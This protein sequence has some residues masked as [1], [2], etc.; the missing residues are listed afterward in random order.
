M[1]ILITGAL[2]QDGQILSDMHLANGD[3]VAGVIRPGLGDSQKNGMS[4]FGINLGKKEVC[5]DFLEYFKPDVIYHLAAVH[6][7]STNMQSILSQNRTSLFEIQSDTTNNFIKY[8]ENHNETHLLVALSS[9]MY[10]SSN[11]IRAIS[12][13]SIV[14]PSDDYGIAKSYSLEVLKNAREKSDLRVSGLI[15]FNHTSRLSKKEFLFPQIAE[16]LRTNPIEQVISGLHNPKALIDMTDAYE[17]CEGIFQISTAGY[18]EEFVIGSGNLFELSELVEQSVGS[19]PF[20]ESKLTT[21][22]LSREGN[23][24]VSNP[25]KMKDYFGWKAKKTPIQILSEMI[26]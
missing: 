13:N 4:Y 5:S 22:S 20:P 14:N 24:L 25:Q 19:I 7:S 2:G 26:R 23:A 11:G 3:E 15:L 17:V 8:M 1:R 10:S 6:G 21:V 18:S 16:S 9:K 12:E